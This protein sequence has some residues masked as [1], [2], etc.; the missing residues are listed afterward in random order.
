MMETKEERALWL[1]AEASQRFRDRL[2]LSGIREVR[3]KIPDNDEAFK[4]L[5]RS[6]KRIN[7]AAKKSK[8]AL[9]GGES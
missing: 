7:N 3:V 9:N 6:V 2:K 4:S 8:A 1:R 5:T